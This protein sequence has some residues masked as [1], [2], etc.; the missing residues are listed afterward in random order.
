M[1]AAH[2]SVRR[3]DWLDSAHDL[4]FL[5]PTSRYRPGPVYC[6]VLALNVHRLAPF[7]DV[8]SSASDTFEVGLLLL[9]EAD[10]L[11]DPGR[12]VESDFFNSADVQ[13][14]LA[15]VEA[16]APAPATLLLLAAGLMG[17]GAARRTRRLR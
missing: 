2:D 13:V 9:T 14:S 7:T 8:P 3:G 15:A 1:A 11:S 5:S 12:S 4:E 10:A 16:A 17:M 6:D